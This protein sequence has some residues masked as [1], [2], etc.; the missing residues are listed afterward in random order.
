LEKWASSVLPD[1]AICNSE[2]TAASWHKTHPRIKAKVVY[3]PLVTTPTQL[4]E[5]RRSAV[6]EA[7]GISKDA[8]IIIQVSRMEEWKGHDL[9]LRALAKLEAQPEWVC[10]QVGGAQRKREASYMEGLKRV[11]ASLG[12]FDR[13]RFLGERSDVSEL[14]PAS[15]IHCQPNKG[16]EPFGNT[17]IEALCA[18][19]PVVTVRM[20]GALEIVDDSC[21]ILVPPND[22]EA[23]A[24]ALQSLIHNSALRQRL[25]ASGFA[26][27]QELTGVQ[28]QM[29]RLLKV[30]REVE[31]SNQR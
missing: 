1:F 21:G 19:L 31:I 25:G 29:K 26:R 15:D 7:L 11:A 23:L 22:S 6:R 28:K 2:F 9:L 17:F 8:V 27:A 13:V 18:G 14:L 12:I 30:F 16:P 3:N 4:P 5:Q 10:L 24:S 20:G